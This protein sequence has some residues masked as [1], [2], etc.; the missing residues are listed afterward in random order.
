ML[1]N[2][3]IHSILSNKLP[4]TNLLWLLSPRREKQKTIH[5]PIPLSAE[6][7]NFGYC[8]V[9][10]KK[11]KKS[12]EDLCRSVGY[13]LNSNDPT[14]FELSIVFHCVSWNLPLRYRGPSAPSPLFQ[15]TGGYSSGDPQ[16]WMRHG[17]QGRL[18]IVCCLTWPQY[19]PVFGRFLSPPPPH[20][21]PNSVW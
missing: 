6:R 3:H 16:H 4:D 15:H 11:K 7:G 18:G 14:R 12:E 5:L 13:H 2:E 17:I 21:S 19:K 10:K 1:F 9:L 8:F 20:R